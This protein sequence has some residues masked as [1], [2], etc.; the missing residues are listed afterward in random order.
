MTEPIEEKVAALA[1]F[2]G[3]LAVRTFPPSAADEEL[4]WRELDREIADRVA[5]R[6]VLVIG[7]EV[8]KDAEAVAAR[9]AEHVLACASPVRLEPTH[10][11]D[12]LRLD[13]HPVTWQELD[14]ERHGTFDLVLCSDLVHRVT[15]PLGLLR[16]LRSVT[17]DGGTLVVE[18]VMIDDPERSEYLRFI[19]DRFAGDPSWWFVP[20]RLAFRWLVQTA[21]FEV[22]AEF[23]ERDGPRDLF[24]VIIAYLR[25]TA[26]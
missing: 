19:P 11:A 26:A 14:P 12:R 2:V 18:S 15:E 17:R 1:R 21:G 16:T 4:R 6:R 13:V 10:D 23:A 7:G 8:V 25:A 3:E 24:P 20:G 22:E 9:N 5:D